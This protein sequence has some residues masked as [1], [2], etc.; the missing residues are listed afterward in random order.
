MR[1]IILDD[2]E[3]DFV[4]LKDLIY[5]YYKTYI[6]YDI[7]S[8]EYAKLVEYKVYDEELER[9]IEGGTFNFIYLKGNLHWASKWKPVKQLFKEVLE[10]EEHVI[11][12]FDSFEEFIKYYNEK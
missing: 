4:Q 12:E 1:E 10:E 8:D 7:E 5:D 9:K 6:L 11:Y 3:I 2:K